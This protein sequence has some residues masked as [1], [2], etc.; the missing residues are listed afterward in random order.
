MQNI[1]ATIF[2]AENDGY[3]A[4]TQL[5]QQ[6][7]TQDYAIL[8]GALIRRS[9]QEFTVLDAFTSGIRTEGGAAVG[10]VLGSLIGIL[11]G[12][13]GV[14]LMGSYG[15]LMGR[16]VGTADTLDD[17]A[18]LEHVAGKLMDGEVALILLAEEKDEA[19][20]DGRLAKFQAE[21]A[22][23]DAAVIAQELEK[24]EEIQAVMAKD[25]LEQI[26][27]QE[28]K[29]FQDKVEEKRN[30]MEAEFNDFLN[31]LPDVPDNF[32]DRNPEEVI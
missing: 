11:G 29:E 2:K 20:L 28:E 6:A 5:R 4:I 13:L 10:G 25:A 27:K 19:D 1:I 3:Q 21:T 26:R 17:A 7:V 31:T 14:L 16:T 24:A 30:K 32:S 15:A 9:G 22:R 8:Q 23:F 12:P 18:L